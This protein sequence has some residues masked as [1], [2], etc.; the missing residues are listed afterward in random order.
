MKR[1]FCFEE[2]RLH[3]LLIDFSAILPTKKKRNKNHGAEKQLFINTKTF[4]Y[5]TFEM[6]CYFFVKKPLSL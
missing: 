6:C 2:L 1:L 4:S 3:F 5:N